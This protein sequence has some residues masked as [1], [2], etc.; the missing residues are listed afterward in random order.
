MAQG[1]TVNTA[2]LAIR[3]G[4]LR[5]LAGAVE[6]AAFALGSTGGN[7]GP[8]DLTSAVA[9][10]SDQWY[11]GLGQMRDK[12]DTMADNVSNAVA[13]YDALDASG[14]EGMRALADNALVSAQL[15]PLRKAAAAIK[16]QRGNLNTAGG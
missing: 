4:E 5:S 3:I 8:G 2:S 13:N 10:V 7:L 12:I 11:D 15:D 1:Y 9:E 6:S 14:A 16:A